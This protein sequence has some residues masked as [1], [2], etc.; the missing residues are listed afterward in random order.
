MNELLV[1][2]LLMHWPLH[3][4][5]IAKMANNILGPEEQISRGTLSSLLAKLEQAGLI[6]NADPEQVRF[7]SDRPSRALAITPAGRE[8]F[9]QLMLDTR[10][11]AG[12]YRRFFHI[13]ALHLEFLSLEHQ[14]FLVEHYLHYCQTIVRDKEAEAQAF[15]K[16]FR[17]QEHMSS[18]FRERALAFM[19]LKAEQWQLEVAWV[20]SLCVQVVAHLQQEGTGAAEGTRLP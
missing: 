2:G 13:K 8:R 10:S 6:T 9:S 1:L 16:S 18:A 7:P 19:R 11:H 14:L 17:K 3:A 12:S 15:A 4:Y 20:Q 5:K